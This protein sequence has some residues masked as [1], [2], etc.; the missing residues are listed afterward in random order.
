[1]IFSGGAPLFADVIEAE[2]AAGIAAGEVAGGEPSVALGK[3]SPGSRG[4][5]VRGVW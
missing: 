1:L 2:E 5:M 3:R 4:V